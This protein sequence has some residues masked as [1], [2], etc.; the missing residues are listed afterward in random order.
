M[1]SIGFSIQSVGSLMSLVDEH[2]EDISD[3]TYLEVCNALKFLHDKTEQ[4]RRPITPIHSPVPTSD[5]RPVG[6][7]APAPSVPTSAPSA[8]SAPTTPT[9][10]TAPMAAYGQHIYFDDLYVLQWIDNPA[11][12]LFMILNRN[13]LTRLLREQQSCLENIRPRVNNYVK[14]TVLRSK[15][16]VMGFDYIQ[17]Q[18]K[19]QSIK[20]NQDVLLA[21]G[22]P[23]ETLRSDYQTEKDVIANRLMVTLS[24]RIER[25]EDILSRI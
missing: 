14:E 1:T 21:N 24:L 11:S 10:P 8:S 3:A 20:D 6:T 2:K 5:V 16:N 23:L 7:T 4:D 12:T 22:V 25:I 17:S 13:Q 9:A 19:S 15:L 18:T